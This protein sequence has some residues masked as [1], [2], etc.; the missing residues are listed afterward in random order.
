MGDFHQ[1]FSVGAF[2]DKNERFKFCY[3][4]VKVK[5]HGRSN[6]LENAVFGLVSKISY[7]LMDG[8]SQNFGCSHLRSRLRSRSRPLQGQIFE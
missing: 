8:I 2:W 3:Q 5:G 7:K 6:M 1:T 4:K